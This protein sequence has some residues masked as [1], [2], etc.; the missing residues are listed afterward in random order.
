MADTL[1]R[2]LIKEMPA[3]ERPRE[4]LALYGEAAL[5]NAELLAI[6]LAT[7]TRRENVV[8]LAQRL[9]MTFNGLDGLAH[10]S[11]AELC[12]VSGIGPAKAAQIKA[13]LALGRRLILAANAGRPQITSPDDAA[14]LLLAAMS[15]EVQ[16]QLRVILLDT[17][18]HV[19]RMAVVYVGN[20]NSAVVRMS[21]V[22]RDAIKDNATAII[23]AHNHPS[24]DPT[25]SPEDLAL[26]V[27]IVKA[28]KLLDI[29][30]LDHIIVGQSTY[31]SLKQRGL[32]SL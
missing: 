21:E 9:L 14:Q 12:D 20:A 2:T 32:G 27:E 30:V 16:E 6:A 18:H 17:R 19:L 28:G 23:V 5:S 31:V 22:F 25:P 3:S 4:R 26:T 1:Y 11:Y 15:G 8:G 10:A 13:A 29:E 24:G 7:G